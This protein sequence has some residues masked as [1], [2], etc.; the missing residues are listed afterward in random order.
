MTYTVHFCNRS[1]LLGYNCTKVLAINKGQIC[2]SKPNFR[3]LCT[4]YLKT[5]EFCHQGL[6]DNIR[7]RACT[8]YRFCSNVALGLFVATLAV[9]ISIFFGGGGRMYVCCFISNT[10]LI[11]FFFFKFLIC[12][13]QGWATYCLRPQAILVRPARPAEGKNQR[14]LPYS[15]IC[16]LISSA[17]Q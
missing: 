1:N 2:N 11:F 7:S 9:L 4:S 5:A 16:Q 13:N 15:H 6:H 8:Y 17:C 10:C 12:I 3:H 14:A